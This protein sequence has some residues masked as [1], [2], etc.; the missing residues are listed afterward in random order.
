MTFLSL[1]GGPRINY[2]N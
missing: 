1:I 2:F